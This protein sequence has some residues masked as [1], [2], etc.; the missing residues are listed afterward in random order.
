MQAVLKPLPF[1]R[2]VSLWGCCWDCCGHYA[3]LLHLSYVSCHCKITAPW[4]FDS[5]AVGPM[6]AGIRV[7]EGVFGGIIMVSQCAEGA[8]LQ[9]AISIATSSTSSWHH[10]L[11]QPNGNALSSC[12]R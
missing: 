3:V 7:L 4:G 6:L 12:L 5:R 8:A 9:F 11:G 1:V 2:I 10:Q